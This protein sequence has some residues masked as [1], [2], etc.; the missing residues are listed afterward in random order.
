MVRPWSWECAL[1]TGMLINNNGELNWLLAELMLASICLKLNTTSTTA[2]QT[3][4][5]ALTVLVDP[6]RRVFAVPVV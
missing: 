2:K 4:G 3:K 5:L 6:P 1:C